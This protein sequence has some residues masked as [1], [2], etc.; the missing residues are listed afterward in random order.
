MSDI[1]VL[2]QDY[3]HTAELFSAINR[4]VILFKKRLAV[5]RPRTKSR[6]W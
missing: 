3:Q 5:D 4:S 6:R 2:S 1:G